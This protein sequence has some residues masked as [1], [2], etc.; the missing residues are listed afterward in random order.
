MLIG[1]F[2]WKKLSKIQQLKK[3]KKEIVTIS[4]LWKFHEKPL[5]SVFKP[6]C[7]DKFFKIRDILS[8]KPL[9]F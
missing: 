3:I 1:T 5:V 9:I 8:D 2:M 4:D 7:G 6:L